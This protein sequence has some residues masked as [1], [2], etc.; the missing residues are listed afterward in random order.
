MTKILI[1]SVY[2]GFVTLNIL[3]ILT[4]KKQK[5]GSMISRLNDTTLRL[6]Q[7]CGILLFFTIIN[8]GQFNS[9]VSYGLVLQNYTL[10]TIALITYWVKINSV[11]TKS[12]ISIS[13]LLTLFFEKLI[14]LITSFELKNWGSE[15]IYAF[16]KTIIYNFFYFSLLIIMY[17]I[18]ISILKL[19]KQ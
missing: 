2:I 9:E 3:S 16:I 4:Y 14:I 8:S 17:N 10:I 12:L 1:E 11:L 15:L 19:R 18:G 13:I 7:I 6:I 5:L